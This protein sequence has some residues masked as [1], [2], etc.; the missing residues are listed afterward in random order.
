MLKQRLT[1]PVQFKRIPK[2]S[3]KSY[4]VNKGKIR[5]ENHQTIFRTKSK[6]L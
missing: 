4:W 3:P 5:W 1:I 2:V 6:N